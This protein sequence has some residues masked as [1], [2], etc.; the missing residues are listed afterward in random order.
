MPND[1]DDKKQLSQGLCE[2][3]S[4]FSPEAVARDTQKAVRELVHEA[5]AHKGEIFVLGCSSSE[6]LGKKIGSCSSP[7]AGMIL[8]DAVKKC[9]DEA[10]LCL[11]VQC[12]EHLNRALIVER[13]TAEKYGLEE[14]SVVPVPKAGGSAATAAWKLF[15]EPVAVLSLKAHLGMDIGQTFIGMHLR[16]VAVPVRLSVK[17]IGSAV[18][19]AA[20]TRPMLIGGVRAQY[21]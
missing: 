4:A 12:C 3:L 15:E 16:R 2:D 11:A 7:E 6:V 10:E 8:V 14:V 18:L 1:F 17:T 5:D 21:E 9:T 13:S 19:T 20:R